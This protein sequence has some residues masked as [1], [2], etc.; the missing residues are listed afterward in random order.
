M[1]EG[2]LEFTVPVVGTNKVKTLYVR[3]EK[4]AAVYSS[5]VMRTAC[6]LVIDGQHGPMH[7]TG[8]VEEIMQKITTA[9]VD[10]ADLV[11]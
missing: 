11:G 9:A 1:T 6:Y 10:T 2:F 7:V 8:T 3:P 5:P 4:I